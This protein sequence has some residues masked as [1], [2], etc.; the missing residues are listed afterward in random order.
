MVKL[1]AASSVREKWLEFYK[2]KE[3][4]TSI[5][6]KY[7]ELSGKRSRKKRDKLNLEWMKDGK[8]TEIL[9]WTESLNNHTYFKD[10]FKNV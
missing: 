7:R 9:P 2:V 8:I 6:E 4:I 1:P 5:K 3:V 10:F